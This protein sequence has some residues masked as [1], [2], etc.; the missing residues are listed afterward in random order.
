MNSIELKKIHEDTCQKCL[1]VMVKKNSDYTG[2]TTSKD[3]F[4]NFR[5]A[6][7]LGIHPV[8]GVLLRIMDKIQRIRSFTNDGSLKVESETVYDACEDIVNYAILAK[9][10]LIEEREELNENEWGQI[11]IHLK[12]EAE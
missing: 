1:D 8:Q 12:D 6:D 10:M 11:K 9:A 7:V 3:V 4:A 5:S 2:G